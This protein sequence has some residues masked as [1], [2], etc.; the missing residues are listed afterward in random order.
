MPG[1][2]AIGEPMKYPSERA[3]TLESY[4]RK[5]FSRLSGKALHLYGALRWLERDRRG[6]CK[7]VFAGQRDMATAAAINIKSV[8]NALLE[9]QREGLCIVK[10]GRPVKADRVATSI[11]R[12]TLAEVQAKSAQGEDDA[13]RLARALSS[14][15][16][17][18][19]GQ[20]IKPTW[21]TGTTGRIMSSRPNI[22][23]DPAS[24]RIAGLVAGLVPGLSLVHADVKAAEPTI[25]K[26]LLA[27][28]A[29]RDLYAEYMATTGCKRDDAKRAI[30]SLAY[31]RNSLACFAHW[32]ATAQD[33]LRDYVEQ[34]HEYKAGLFKTSRRTRTI[35]TLAGRTIRADKGQ[36]IHPGRIMNWRV[37]GTVA[38]VVNAACLSL[39]AEASVII[40]LHDAVYAILDTAKASLVESAITGKAHEIGL[41]FKVK[42]EVRHG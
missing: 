19:H 32:P 20:T 29:E 42:S 41:A 25:I 13:A 5:R 4:V 27:I 35:T 17:C 22:Q 26:S 33:Q 14:R 40:P 9:L 10:I 31:C 37:Q 3:D 2:P 16:F 7:P 28:P 1:K 34:L 8:K 39:L 12:L 21:T 11:R 18:Y 36:R 30:N 6:L 38:D 23:G 15:S 24:K